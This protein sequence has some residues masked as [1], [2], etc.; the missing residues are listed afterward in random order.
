MRRPG[1]LVA[2]RVVLLDVQQEA[3]QQ[4]QF[5]SAAAGG[6]GAA[7]ASGGCPDRIQVSET[8]Q[9]LVQVAV[10]DSAV[11]T[12]TLPAGLTPGR[13]WLRLRPHPA[14]RFNLPLVIFIRGV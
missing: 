9:V 3:L 1:V 2:V 6:R 8:G 4:G 10:E 11:S 13:T 14:R 7:G 5:G 12:V